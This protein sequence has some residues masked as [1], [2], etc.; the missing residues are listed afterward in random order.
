MIRQNRCI[1]QILLGPFLN[2]LPQ[3]SD[4]KG[5]YL[6]KVTSKSTDLQTSM[7]VVFILNKYLHTE[8]KRFQNER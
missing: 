5:K 3:M 8:E 7:N 4:T 2:T 6:L 1:P